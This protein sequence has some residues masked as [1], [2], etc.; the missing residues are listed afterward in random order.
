M[1]VLLQ[2]TKSDKRIEK[3]SFPVDKRLLKMAPWIYNCLCLLTIVQLLQ[4][5]GCA[6]QIIQMVDFTLSEEQPP[7]QLLGNL[8]T[9]TGLNFSIP[10]EYLKDTR[11]SLNTNSQEYEEYFTFEDGTG[12]YSG[13]Y[14][15]YLG[16]LV[17]EEKSNQIIL[18]LT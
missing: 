4:F 13:L 3:N 15:Q 6:G 10:P 12:M 2:L 14:I 8:L 5:H 11:I 7:T 16:V 9:L 17:R 18:V 1:N